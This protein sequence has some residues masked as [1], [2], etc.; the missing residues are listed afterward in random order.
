M[1]RGHGAKAAAYSVA[2]FHAGD[3]TLTLPRLWNGV[4][5]RSEFRAVQGGSAAYVNQ[6]NPETVI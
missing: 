3:H 1:K 2:A 6:L 5:R 4:I